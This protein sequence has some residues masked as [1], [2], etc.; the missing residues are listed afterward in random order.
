MGGVSWSF[1]SRAEFRPPAAFPHPGRVEGRPD[2]QRCRKRLGPSGTDTNG[3]PP[4]LRPDRSK[5]GQSGFSAGRPRRLLGPGSW[6]RPRAARGPGPSNP[7]LSAHTRKVFSGDRVPGPL[8]GLSPALSPD[9]AT[10]DAKQGKGGFLLTDLGPGDHWGEA[11]FPVG[12]V[13]AIANLRHVGLPS[14][15]GFLGILSTLRRKIFPFLEQRDRCPREVPGKF[16]QKTPGPVDEGKE[17]RSQ[18]SP[19]LVHPMGHSPL[20]GAVL[21]SQNPGPGR[22]VRKCVPGESFEGL[23]SI[24]RIQVRLLK[25][26]DVSVG[27][28][29]RSGHK[30]DLIVPVLDTPQGIQPGR[31]RGNLLCLGSVLRF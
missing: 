21:G 31:S 9:P 2:R 23:H 20:K 25:E 22:P 5:G 24:Q 18:T 10:E 7:V 1:R 14:L 26:Q 15:D 16:F 29:Q 13:P 12:T 3:S 28:R 8:P 4:T 11:E 17:I 27:G 6:A 30:P 19:P